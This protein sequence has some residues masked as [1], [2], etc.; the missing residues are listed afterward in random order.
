MAGDLPPVSRPIVYVPEPIA[1]VGLDLLAEH[2]DCRA[3][4]ST[5]AEASEIP[6]GT[7]AILLRTYV[8]DEARLDSAPELRVVAKHGVG[9]VTLISRQRRNVRLPCSGPR[10]PTP[11]PSP[12]TR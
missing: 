1:Q 3:P 12:S 8:L 4:W 10:R 6:L 5:G 7:E 2:C 9:L 11:T